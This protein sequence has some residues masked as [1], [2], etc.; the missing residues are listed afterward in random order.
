MSTTEDCES[1]ADQDQYSWI[2]D[3][4]NG[5]RIGLASVA[6]TDSLGQ[7]LKETHQNPLLSREAEQEVAR[8]LRE[9]ESVLSKNLPRAKRRS[10]RI[11]FE[12][13]R[14]R[15]IECNLR[16][17]VSIAKRYKNMGLE[18]VDLIQEGNIGLIQ[19]VERFDPRRNLKFSTYATWWIRQAVTRALSQKSRTVRVPINK[20]ELARAASRV[21]DQLKEQ[22]GREP[23]LEEISQMLGAPQKNVEASLKSISK[24]ESLDAPAIEGGSARSELRS[25]DGSV[26]P[27]E[28]TVARDMREKIQVVLK[29]LAPRQALIMRMRY[30][31]G[32]SFEHNL[33]EIGRVLDLTRERVRQL[34]L[35]SLRRLRAVGQLRGL[36]DFLSD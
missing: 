28:A 3:E 30:G 35:D 36:R 29:V 17:V 2:R 13:S 32:F 24:M 8:S 12:R 1:T 21:R 31:I 34:E 11:Q 19:A 6:R 7:Y 10:A 18:L 22:S 23:T 5:D 20:I 25:E 15:M 14:Q 9:S 26:S 4:S 16:L 33:E 27:L